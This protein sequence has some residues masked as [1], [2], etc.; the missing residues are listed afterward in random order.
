MAGNFEIKLWRR[1]RE[2]LSV[3]PHLVLLLEQTNLGTE[4]PRVSRRARYVKNRQAGRSRLTVM[5]S[6][7]ELGRRDVAE[8]FKQAAPCFSHHST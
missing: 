5:I 6:L 7:L 2:R 1:E 3:A 4:P 8:R